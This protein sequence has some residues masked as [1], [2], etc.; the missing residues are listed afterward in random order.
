MQA[1]WQLPPSTAQARLALDLKASGI[2]LPGL[3][4][5][6]LQAQLDG[7]WAAHRLQLK[8]SGP[9][10]W[11]AG[12]QT[13][14]PCKPTRKAGSKA[15]Q[16]CSACNGEAAWPACS[17]RRCA[18]A[19]AAAEAQD[20]ALQASAQGLDFAPAQA[21]IAGARIAWQTLRWQPKGHG[22]RSPAR[23]APAALRRLPCCWPAG[24]PTLAGRATCEWVAAPAGNGAQAGS[25]VTC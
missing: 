7:N 16:T 9:R 15:C 5:N 14:S 20:L 13:R 1:R 22:R 12:R 21:D 18:P 19:A 10:P 4:L 3:Q 11:P 23:P 8:A 17:W 25:M 2:S 24:S 6:E